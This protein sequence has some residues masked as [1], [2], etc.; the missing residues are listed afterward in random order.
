MFSRLH[1]DLRND[2]WLCGSMISQ[3]DDEV[4]IYTVQDIFVWLSI[5]R[6]C[7]AADLQ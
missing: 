4:G 2:A 6:K 7:E 5:S 1:Q 3:F